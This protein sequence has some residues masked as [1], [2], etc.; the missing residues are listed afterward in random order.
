M[1]R[2][3]RCFKYTGFGRSTGVRLGL[4]HSRAVKSRFLGNEGGMVVH[5]NGREK[6]KRQM[7][8]SNETARRRAMRQRSEAVAYDAAA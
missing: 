3:D 8:R 1:M 6:H 4:L 5:Y 7:Q 2:I